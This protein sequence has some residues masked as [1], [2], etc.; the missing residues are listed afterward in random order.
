MS[1]HRE[2]LVQRILRC[3]LTSKWDFFTHLC[4]FLSDVVGSVF[5]FRR[6]DGRLRR[7]RGVSLLLSR[8][9][10]VES[11]QRDLVDG[12]IF[13]DVRV[14]GRTEQAGLHVIKGA[15]RCRRNTER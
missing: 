4:D 2:P 7:R 10:E 1:A 8:L 15:W 6:Y 12:A 14:R 9:G 5:D 3:S 11:D 13:V